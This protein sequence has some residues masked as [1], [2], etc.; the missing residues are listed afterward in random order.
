MT[1]RDSFITLLVS[2]PAHPSH[3]LMPTWRICT[4]CANVIL[5]LR[6]KLIINL[7]LHDQQETK[8]NENGQS[9]SHHF[10]HWFPKKQQTGSF[11]FQDDLFTLLFHENSTQPNLSLLISK[12]N[13]S[14]K[15]KK[16]NKTAGFRQHLIILIFL[17]FRKTKGVT[18]RFKL[19]TEDGMENVQ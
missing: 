16:L 17:V 7:I 18:Y 3:Q 10:H 11:Q 6:N 19:C 12:L 9:R 1:L 13:N 2:W 14:Q 8:F 15:L 4:F 5:L